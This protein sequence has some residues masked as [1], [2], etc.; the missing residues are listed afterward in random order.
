MHTLTRDALLFTLWSL[1]IWTT[2]W[3]VAFHMVVTWRYFIWSASLIRIVLATCYN[4]SIFKVS[5]STR[6]KATTTPEST[7]S[8]TREQVIRWNVRFFGSFGV[9]ANTISHCFRGTKRLKAKLWLLLISFTSNIMLTYP[10]CTF[11][12]ILAFQHLV[13][14]VVSCLSHDDHTRLLHKGGILCWSYTVLLSQYHEIWNSS[15]RLTD[16][17]HYI[18]YHTWR[19]H[20]KRASHLLKCE[21]FPLL[22]S[23][24][25]HGQSSLPWHQ[26]PKL[27]S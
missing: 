3:S 7:P 23:E 9:D 21:V 20:N 12:C 5:P 18:P 16:I 14:K 24:C 10:Q 17:H 11:F 22:W 13:H 19:S 25:I 8:T 4:T 26:T 6:R 1:N 15:M 2:R 27:K